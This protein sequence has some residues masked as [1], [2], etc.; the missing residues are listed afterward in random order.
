MLLLDLVPILGKGLSA[1]VRLGKAAMTALRANSRLLPHLIKNP[2][3]GRG[4]YAD[5]TLAAARIPNLRAAP[6][7]PV[8]SASTTAG[9]NPVRPGAR[10][11]PAPTGPAPAIASA[12][13]GMEQ[14]AP[15][16]AAPSRDLSAYAKAD[17]IVLG[18]T[19]GTNGTYNVDGDWYIRFTDSTGVSK[20]YQI[21]SAFHASSGRA[22]IIDPNAPLTANK[23]SRIVASVQYAGNGEW[24]LNRLP[25]GAPMPVAGTSGTGSA[26]AAAS[27]SQASARE[28]I[29]SEYFSLTDGSL[30][31][32][33]FTPTKLP[34]FRTWF[35]RDMARF[36]RNILTSGQMPPRPPRLELSPGT[37]PADLLRK[38]YEVT[39]VVVLGESHTDIA[40]FKMIQEAMPALKEAGV[41]T[42]YL[43]NMELNTLK[44]L[45]D[46]GMGAHRPAGA[47]PTL[48]ELI[49]LANDNGITVKPLEHH[50]LTRRSDMPDFYKYV[51]DNDNGITRLQEFNYFATRVIQ[52]RKP[53]EKVLALVGRAHMNTARNVPGLA[54]LNGGIGIGVYPNTSF[55]KSTAISGPS[56]R[57]A[58]GAGVTGSHTVG[59]YQVFQQVT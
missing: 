47:S 6:M 41:T 12:S 34:V 9:A 59:D 45:K 13:R 28:L 10:A 8:F 36:Y 29:D 2:G 35:R 54:E 20:V 27:P 32:H 4:I 42:L 19:L 56:I 22:N 46:V 30:V 5:F 24:R 23:S 43:E 7:R 18:R 1:G 44:Q 39:D 58:P 49:K 31:E 57:R 21:D 51:G 17:D 14:T 53:G 48:D 38:A 26:E 40:S 11:L 33:H 16:V 37:P 50:Y 15:L 25:G 55:S 3:L 52:R